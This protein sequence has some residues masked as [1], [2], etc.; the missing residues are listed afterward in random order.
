MSGGVVYE[1]F[2]PA[3]N[4]DKTAFGIAYGAV[5]EDLQGK[6]FELLMELSYIIHISKWLRIQPDIQ[7]IV[8]PGGSGEIPNALVLG[9]Q[10]GT[11]I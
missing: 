4:K 1:G 5:S 8:H 11:D 3:R 9:V 10:L 6:D 7:Y 2:L